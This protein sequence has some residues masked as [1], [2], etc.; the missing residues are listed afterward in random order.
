MSPLR[1]LLDKAKIIKQKNFSYRQ[2]PA[3]W[4]TRKESLQILKNFRRLEGSWLDGL[5]KY[6]SIFMP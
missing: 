5:K 2:G 3:M 4:R 1:K 6:L